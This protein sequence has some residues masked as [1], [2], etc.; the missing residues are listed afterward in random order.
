MNC[1]CTFRLLLLN[2]QQT[3]GALNNSSV[4]RLAGC[5]SSA[6]SVHRRLKH[7]TIP[8]SANDHRQLNRANVS[9]VAAAVAAARP[10]QM[11][12][13][14]YEYTFNCTSNAPLTGDISR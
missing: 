7:S 5:W 13:T 14:V 8:Y 4:I 2:E 11:E 6:I 9:I 3:F 1:M 12:Q 10:V